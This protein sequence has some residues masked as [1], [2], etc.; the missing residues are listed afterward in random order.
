MILLATALK[1]A[2]DLAREIEEATAK[3]VVV[4]ASVS[5]ATE[6]LQ[7]REFS[8]VVLDELLFDAEPE[9]G[10]TVVKHFGGAVPIY[11][12]FAICSKERVVRELRSALERR[13]REISQARQE[14]QD[15]LRHDL[16]ET[17]TALLLSCEMALRDP[18]LPASVLN[19]MQTVEALARDVSIKLGGAH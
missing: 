12:N 19:R 3:S 18:D 13:K 7:T 8:A 2:S 4:C 10:D 14:A 11:V 5:E 9:A 16:R 1:K 6:Q 15:A 17:V